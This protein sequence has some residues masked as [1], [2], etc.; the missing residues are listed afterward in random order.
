MQTFIIIGRSVKQHRYIIK[1]GERGGREKRE[2]KREREKREERKKERKIVL[3]RCTFR[4]GIGL[5]STFSIFTFAEQH[6][7][8]VTINTPLLDSQLVSSLSLYIYTYTRCGS[9]VQC[10]SILLSFF[11]TLFFYLCCEYEYALQ[12]IRANKAIT[13]AS[14]KKKLQAGSKVYCGKWRNLYLAND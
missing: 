5:P 14:H 3:A 8:P 7:Y 10:F 4:Q 13:H 11:L 9:I 6:F 1:R 2:E 12:A